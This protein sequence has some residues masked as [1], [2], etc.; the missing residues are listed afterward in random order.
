MSEPTD[1]DLL[2]IAERSRERARSQRRKEA[3]TLRLGS[4]EVTSAVSPEEL[5]LSPSCPSPWCRFRLMTEREQ[6]RGVCDDCAEQKDTSERKR[7]QAEKIPPEFRGHTLDAFPAFIRREDA[8][9]ARTWLEASGRLLTIG[10]RREEVKGGQKM[11]TNPTASGKTTLA[12]MVAASAAARGMLVHW[13]NA[14]HL[15]PVA[16]ERK[17]RETYDSI[18]M[19]RSG[20]VVIDGLGKEMAG[21]RKETDIH[22]RR[23]GLTSKLPN[24]IH[25]SREKTR[26]VI[27]LDVTGQYGAETYGDAEMR[28]IASPR[29]ATVIVLTRTET[30]D[31]IKI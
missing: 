23:K 10:A 18:F 12:A 24:D 5:K 7:K 25:T 4:L 31:V 27:T 20:I 17:A 26:F 21:A 14:A 28:R 30:L 3:E 9:T 2:A 6:T 29:H 1:A 16:D 8:A 13:I 19:Q 11:I 15:D 22:D